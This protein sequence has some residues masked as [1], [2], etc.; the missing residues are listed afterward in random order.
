MKSHRKIR[1]ILSYHGVSARELADAIGITPSTLSKKMRGQRDWHYY[2]DVVPMLKYLKQLTG[3]TYTTEQ[4][5]E[6][7]K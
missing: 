3:K 1:A 2:Q 6:E 5:M 4:L 7:V